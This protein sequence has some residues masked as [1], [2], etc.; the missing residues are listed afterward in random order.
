MNF[1]KTSMR[2]VEGAEKKWENLDVPCPTPKLFLDSIAGAWKAMEA[3]PP[4][5]VEKF[6]NQ[7]TNYEDD[8]IFELL[9]I[10]R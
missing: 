6:L 3:D 4:W 5:S 10:S 8:P 7:M 2:K 9:D 1:V